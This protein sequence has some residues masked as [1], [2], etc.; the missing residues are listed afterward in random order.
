MKQQLTKN[1]TQK[2]INIG[3]IISAQLILIILFVCTQHASAS[4]VNDDCSGAITLT[5]SD[6]CNPVNGTTI[7]ATQSPQG[8]CAGGADDDVWFTFIATANSVSIEIAT[9]DPNFRGA[10]ECWDGDCSGSMT[11]LNCSYASAVGSSFS[12]SDTGLVIGSHYWIRVYSL[13]YIMADAGPF[14]ICVRNVCSITCPSNVQ[15]A[16]AQGLCDV[17]VNYPPVITSGPCSGISLLPAD[18][19]SFHVGTTPVTVTSSTGQTCS[20]DVTVNHTPISISQIS[21]PNNVCR[22]TSITYCVQPV[23]GAVSYNWTIPAGATGSSSTNCITLTFGGNFISGTLIVTAFSGCNTGASAAKLLDVALTKPAKPAGITPG[24]PVCAGSSQFFCAGFIP[25]AEQY[26]FTIG[27][28]GG[29]AP[30]TFGTQINSCITLNIPAGYNNKQQLKV[31]T[32]NC[33]GTSDELKYDIKVLDP[34]NMPGN[35]SGPASVCKS[36]L[37][38]Y[39]ISN[40][41]N[42]L[43][44]NWSVSNGVYISG[45]QG[46]TNLALD[47]IASTANSALLSVTAQNG[48]GISAPRT[49]LINI[50]TSCREAADEYQAD[51]II[52]LDAKA[53]PNPTS[54]KVT[55]EYTAAETS[56]FSLKLY[57]MTGRIVFSREIT[58]TEGLNTEELN[59]ENLAKQIYLLRLENGNESRTI[60]IAVE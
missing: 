7:G 51:N 58:A 14:N 41:N 13:S 33:M 56:G 15:V 27:G 3:R 54:G 28:N 37:G 8:I 21:G 45:G 53:F 18:G 30:L 11:L 49:K 60:R 55:L 10:A 50:N 25:G 42:A 32:V 20:F 48:C 26:I 52:S 35:I 17:V 43:T 1:T 38:F 9:T 23:Q 12:L 34:S 44:Y 59:F 5:P 47:Y 22:G 24:G 29:T 31:R 57:D 39:S 19:S 16:T 4:V 6:N 46:T 36:Q 40:V 2:L